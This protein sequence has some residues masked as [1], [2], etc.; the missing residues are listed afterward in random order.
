MAIDSIYGQGI[1]ASPSTGPPEYAYTIMYDY[2]GNGNVIYI[3]YALSSPKP[4]PIAGFPAQTTLIPLTGP[5]TS[6]AYW[7][8]KK[9]TYNG[10]LQLTQVQWVNGNTQ[11]SSIWDNRASLNYQ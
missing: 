4:G 11:Q 1:D 3:G 9:F 8:I 5:V 10:S 2:D 6:G 7:A